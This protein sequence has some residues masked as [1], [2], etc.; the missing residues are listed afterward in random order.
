M[1]QPVTAHPADDGP[2]TLPHTHPFDPTYGYDLAALRRVTAPLGPTDF[3]AFWRGTW[4]EAQ[5]TPLNL[6]AGGDRVWF[7]SHAWRRVWFDAPRW[8]PRP[9]GSAAAATHRVGG[10]LALPLDRPARW[11]AVV[12]HGYG[13]RMTPD[14]PWRDAAVLFPC[15]PG[16]HRSRADDVPNNA[17]EHVV[18]GIGHRD[19]YLIRD[20]VAATW[21]AAAALLALAPEVAP[22]LH[23]HGQSFGGGVGALALPWDHRYQS[24]TLVIP[25]FGHHPIRLTCPCTGSGES[26]RRHH[27]AH[28]EVPET[29]AYY[30]AATAATRINIPTLAAPA[31]FDPAVPPPGQYA[32]ANALPNATRYDRIAGHH[33]WPGLQADLL[34]FERLYAAWRERVIT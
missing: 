12:G 19:T 34:R 17:A 13:G 25:T 10:W 22:R 27:A 9:D 11:G 32:V 31:R 28:P 8:A 3:D 7:E 23:Y 20:C 6:A 16:F 15:M 5:R 30:D 21:A 14:R 24:A 1:T 33:E 4:D 18:L 26:V 29:L 2:A